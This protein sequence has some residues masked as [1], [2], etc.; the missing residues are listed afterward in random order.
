MARAR[1]DP[2]NRSVRSLRVRAQRAAATTTTVGAK[3]NRLD[4]SLKFRRDRADRRNRHA[5]NCSFQSRWRYSGIFSVSTLIECSPPDL[6]TVTTTVLPTGVVDT[7]LGSDVLS[8]ALPSH[9]RI[10]SPT[11]RSARIAGVAAFTSVISA[12]LGPGRPS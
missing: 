7:T 10:T 8:T 3:R 6:H 2:R 4:D 12:P 9:T 5:R 11:R 1:L